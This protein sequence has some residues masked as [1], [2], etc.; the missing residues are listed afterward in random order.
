VSL[1]RNLDNGLGCMRNG[2]ARALELTTAA[3]NA[4]DQIARRAA[5]SG[6]TGMA[7]RM[8]HVRESI[9]QLHGQIRAVGLSIN[10]ACT[11][12]GK[13]PDQLSPK[14]TIDLLVPVEEQ[15]GAIQDSTCAA[16]SGIDR[17]RTE[18]AGALLG[19]RPEEMLRRLDAITQVLHTVVQLGT[20]A[21]QH[22][23]TALAEARQVGAAG[24][25]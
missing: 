11:P 18:T 14:D 9:Q 8:A 7:Q 17:L 6:F 4:A 1:L 10:D 21:K 23:Q 19:G 25:Q 22:V 13:A 15:I 20:D 5:G 24:N 12:V 3:A 16:V 2:V